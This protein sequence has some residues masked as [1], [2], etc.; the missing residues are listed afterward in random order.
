M[1]VEFLMYLPKI[2][3]ST[4]TKSFF[5]RNTKLVKLRVLG[6]TAISNP[7]FNILEIV[8]EMPFIDTEPFPTKFFLY[9]LDNLK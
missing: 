9:F 2:S 4:F 3:N 1:I 5:L 8:R 7:S 6:I